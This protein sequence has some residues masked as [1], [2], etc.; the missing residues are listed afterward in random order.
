LSVGYAQ[1]QPKVAIVDVPATIPDE[2]F[3]FLSLGLYFLLGFKPVFQN[4]VSAVLNLWVVIRIYF[5]EIMLHQFF[6]H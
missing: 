4:S 1:A 6:M 3:L 2:L 5:S